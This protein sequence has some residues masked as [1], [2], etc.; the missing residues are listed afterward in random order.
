MS[1]STTI[2]DTLDVTTYLH[3]LPTYNPPLSITYKRLSR[4]D[5][6]YSRLYAIDR[7][8]LYVSHRMM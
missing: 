5:S 2:G 8:G 4:I 3:L 7:G 6:I 1:N